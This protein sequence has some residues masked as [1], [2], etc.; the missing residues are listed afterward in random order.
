MDDANVNQVPVID[1]EALLG[2][3]SREQVLRYVCLRAELGL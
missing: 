1:D 2:V 3:L